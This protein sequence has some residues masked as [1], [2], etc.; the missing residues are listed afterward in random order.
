MLSFYF[1]R[2]ILSPFNLKAKWSQCWLLTKESMFPRTGCISQTVTEP[3]KARPLQIVQASHPCDMASLTIEFSV[4][5]LSVVVNRKMSC[6]LLSLLLKLYC[7]KL[8]G[9]LIS[10]TQTFFVPND[11][12]ISLKR[13][14][15]SHMG[16][17]LPGAFFS[18]F[19]FLWK[20]MCKDK[21]TELVS[22]ELVHP[23]RL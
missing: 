12:L 22:V 9:N 5:C 17:L 7:R 21:F 4:M 15:G 23:R 13:G 19:L 11:L 2:S 10:F 8:L 6:L 16:L 1:C 20:Q 3:S 14:L 18:H